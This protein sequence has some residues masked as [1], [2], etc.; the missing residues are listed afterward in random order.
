MLRLPI[1]NW[2][3]L[4]GQHIFGFNPNHSTKTTKQFRQTNYRWSLIL[5]N[6]NVSNDINYQNSL[7]NPMQF[8]QGA[9]F[10]WTSEYMSSNTI[11]AGCITHVHQYKYGSAKKNFHLSC[12]SVLVSLWPP[13]VLSSCPH[14]L[15]SACPIVLRSSCPPFLLPSCPP[16]IVW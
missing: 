3:P 13:I 10:T 16:I 12:P 11:T 4:F 2:Q 8:S 5:N 14:V 1:L 9:V 7:R 6:C 15:L